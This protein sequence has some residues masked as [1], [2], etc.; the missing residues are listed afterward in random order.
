[1]TERQVEFA[2]TIHGGTDLLHLIQRYS[3]SLED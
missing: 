2:K 1:M 3:R